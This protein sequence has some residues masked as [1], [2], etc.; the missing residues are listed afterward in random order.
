VPLALTGGG[1][2]THAPLPVAR[3]EVAATAFGRDLAVAGGFLENGGSSRRVDFYAPASDTWRAGPDL[4]AGVNHAAAA[5][6]KGRL[7]VVGGYGAERSTFVLR[8]GA[9]QTLTMPAP[10]AAAGAAA[11][12]GSVYV[13]G[14]VGDGGNARTMLAYDTARG[15]WRSLPGP[16][17]RQHLAVTA[18][19][20]RVYAIAGRDSGLQSNKT[21]VESWAPGEKRWRREAPV[22][23]A[24]G[25]TGA[26]TVGGT[27]VS[28]GGEAPGGT[29]RRVYA[30]DVVKRR[31]SRIPDLPT[32][33]HGLGV[34]ALGGRVYVIGGGPQP[35]LYVSDANESLA[36]R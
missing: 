28:V 29:L 35:G 13:V 19:R 8:G 24:R 2:S 36:V 25:G 30:Y 1:W 32:P 26:A 10:R 34:A 20:G 3:T 12:R 23:E 17:P 9:W 5:V 11:L 16:K 4:P 14:G 21:L 33:R 15:R 18:A 27:I 7:Y 22:P 6:A 31:W